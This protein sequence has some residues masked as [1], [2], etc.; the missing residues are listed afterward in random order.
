MNR[1][2]FRIFFKNSISLS[3]NGEILPKKNTV[4]QNDPSSSS[5]S[6]LDRTGSLFLSVDSTTFLS[7]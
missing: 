5:V 7:F 6:S 1:I 4:G 3:K 2:Y